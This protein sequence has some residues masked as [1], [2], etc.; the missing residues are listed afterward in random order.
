M[1]SVQLAGT[2][3]GVLAVARA[4]ARSVS[5][6]RRLRRTVWR[7]LDSLDRARP[8]PDT[9]PVARGQQ[10]RE[11][12]PTWKVTWG[13]LFALAMVATI[14]ATAAVG[15][16]GRRN[17]YI[18]PEAA[19]ALGLPAL[20]VAAAVTVVLL[21]VPIPTR[22]ER[23]GTVICVT[24]AIMLALVLGFRGLIGS[25]DGRGFTAQQIG[26]W[27]VGA[28]VLLLL[29]LG[30]TARFGRRR[31][32]APG[33]P[34]PRQPRRDA[35]DRA[36]H[37]LE[38]AARTADLEPESTAERELVNRDWHDRLDRLAE[39][40][41]DPDL[42]AQARALGPVAWLAWTFYDDQLN[43]AGILPDR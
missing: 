30:L 28:A 11:S 36:R 26:P 38:F 1:K 25:A 17:R 27:L 6:H 35:R 18:D 31:R 41:T 42:L 12:A 16:A 5:P 15:P 33:R 13:I 43:V 14:V 21:L 32:R 34:P 3:R 23:V 39:R 37:R 20:A 40:G 7:H 9:A 29:L 22:A 8:T 2:D 19:I 4:A 24:V 10:S